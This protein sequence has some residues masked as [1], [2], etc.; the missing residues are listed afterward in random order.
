MV[1]ILATVALV[2]GGVG[3]GWPAMLGAVAAISV[4]VAVTAFS[5]VEDP[6]RRWRVVGQAALW[7]AVGATMLLGLPRLMGPWS[8]LVLAVLGALCPLLL[9]WLAGR[10][11]GP[12]PVR[13]AVQVQR[14]PARELERRWHRTGR[15]L[16][17]GGDAAAALVLVQE[18]ALLLDEIE[19]RDPQ[20]FEALLVRAGWREPQDR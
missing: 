13:T 16:R 8:L 15:E 20:G 4:A 5:W 1:A 7:S 18:R 3:I 2:A 10:L 9:E 11:P 19:R 6:Q 14:L 12:R 17:E